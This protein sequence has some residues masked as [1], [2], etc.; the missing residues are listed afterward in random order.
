MPGDA[1][2]SQFPPNRTAVSNSPLT[3]RF[4]AMLTDSVTRLRSSVP[5]PTYKRLDRPLELNCPPRVSSR[6]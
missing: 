6:M 2:R 4:R 3:N 1:I 5:Y